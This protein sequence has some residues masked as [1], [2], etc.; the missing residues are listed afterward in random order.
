MTDPTRRMAAMRRFHCC[1]HD[2]TPAYAPETQVM[3]RDLAPLLGR[4]L[5]FGVVP[6]WHGK[7]PLAA[8]PDYCRLVREGAEELLLHGYFHQ[9]HRGR[10][11]VSVLTDRS[12]EMNGL[13]PE[14]TRRT[15]ER[16]QRVFIEAFGATARGFL[17]PGWQPGHVHAYAQGVGDISPKLREGGRLGNGDTLQLEYVLGLFSL[18][19][20]AGRKV[21]LAT[22]AW[23]CGRWG[24]LG[25][26]GHGMG[27]LRQ[28]LDR[29]IPVLAIHP[30]DLERG[31]WPT[32]LRLTEEL[33][34]SG[35][36]P[37]T[38]A[39]LLEASNVQGAP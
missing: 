21:P 2:A 22:W 12:D 37:S 33:L 5:S 15:I 24:W 36:E 20:R 4:R 10:G 1:I 3:L 16:G 8:H 9:R 28:S 11:P 25:H 38:L 17:A 39:E 29:G 14:E 23:D 7:W 13:N 31:F 30:R 27:W 35:Y 32:I 6:D 19:S 34:E 26:I 18:E